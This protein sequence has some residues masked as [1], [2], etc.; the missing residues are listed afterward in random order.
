MQARTESNMCFGHSTQSLNKNQIDF[1]PQAEFPVKM[2]TPLLIGQ[3]CHHYTRWVTYQTKSVKKLTKNK[4]DFCS[5]AQ[6]LI[7]MMPNLNLGN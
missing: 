7:T 2:K 4:I 1:P 6:I 3:P 5:L